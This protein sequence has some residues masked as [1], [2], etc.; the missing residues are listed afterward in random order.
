MKNLD[1]NNLLHQN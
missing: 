1:L